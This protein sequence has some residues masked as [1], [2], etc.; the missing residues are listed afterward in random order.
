MNKTYEC[1]NGNLIVEIINNTAV[2]ANGT[3]VINSETRGK[4]DIVSAKVIVGDDN[5]KVGTTIFFSY[6]A[7]QAFTL[8][9]KEV[10]IV[11]K[12]DIKF[13]NKEE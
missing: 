7:G 10:F 12:A 1:R 9:D 13:V 11:N 2:N 3:V 8:E 5:V 4:R 6:Y